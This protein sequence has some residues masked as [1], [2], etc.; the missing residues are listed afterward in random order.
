MTGGKTDFGVIGH[1]V[2]HSVSPAMHNAV[3]AE[4]GLSHRYDKFDVAP[5][6]LKKA[7]DRFEADGF[8]GLN[9]TIPHKL[10]VREHLTDI[11]KEAQLIGA[12]NT[13]LFDEDGRQGHNTDGFGAV[14]A[15]REAGL[16]LHDRNILVLGA[17]GAGRAIATQCLL[18]KACVAITDVDERKAYAL[19]VELSDKTEGIACAIESNPE[20]LKPII[21]RTDILINATPVGMHPDVDAAPLPLDLLHD[22]LAVMDVIYNPRETKLLAAARELDCTAVEGIG[23]LVHQGAESLNVWL[24][25]DPPVD[26]MRKAALDAMAATEA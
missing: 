22:D 8:L 20:T 6:D 13:I 4:M 7:L 11:S 15:L 17:G 10:A 9:V 18:E 3:F 1:P 24:D 14:A 5:N 25:V 21:A 16:E 23:M 26:V 12:V 2:S 19:A